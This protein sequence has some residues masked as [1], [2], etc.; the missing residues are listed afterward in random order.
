[1]N[2]SDKV[3]GSN[4]NRWSLMTIKYVCMTK[5]KFVCMYEYNCIHINALKLLETKK[6][7]Y[8][9]DWKEKKRENKQGTCYLT[10]SVGK[11]REVHAWHSNN[12]WLMDLAMGKAYINI[13]YV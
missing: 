5:C 6:L 11:G 7:L 13:V 4:D 2:A 3:N 12:V 8:Y 10:G 1:M 9:A